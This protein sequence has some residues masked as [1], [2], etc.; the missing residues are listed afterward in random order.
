MLT[1]SRT[2]SFLCVQANGLIVRNAV[3]Q[4]AYQGEKHAANLLSVQLDVP[5]PLDV[6]RAGIASQQQVSIKL[7]ER[8]QGD[9]D[10]D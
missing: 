2:W 9:F 6:E 4:R 7:V 10:K 1:I 8:R 5:V 3:L